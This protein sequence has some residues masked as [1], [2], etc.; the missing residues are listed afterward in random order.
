MTDIPEP[1]FTRERGEARVVGPDNQSDDHLER[2]L[3]PRNMQEFTGQKRIV[4]Q[5]LLA[6]EAARG[7]GESL[8]HVLLYGPPGLGKTTLAHIIAN[9]MGSQIHTT[10]GP[11]LEK[12]ADLAGIL[13]N[14]EAGDV[15]FVDEIHRMG[16]VVEECLYPAMED[17]VID[18]VVDQGPHGRSIQIPLQPFTLVGATTRTGMLTSPLRDRFPITHRLQF[19]SNEEMVKILMRSAEVLGVTLEEEGAHEIASRSRS[20]PRIANRL[21]SRARDYAQ[22][23]ADNVITADVARSAMKLLQVDDLGLDETDRLFLET[24]IDKFDGGPVGLKSL[25]VAMAEDSE[26]VEEVFEPYLIQIGFL[27]RTPQG[28]VATRRAWEHIGRTFPATGTSHTVTPD[29]FEE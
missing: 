5:L 12:R 6:I 25:A 10:A 13:T 1:A 18:I 16:R 27:N 26:T 11:V 8:D 9:E 20:T 7:R 29:L 21:L 15:L 24:L 4:E 2:T 3:R 17:H 14:L 19:Y 28:R 22:V 23:K